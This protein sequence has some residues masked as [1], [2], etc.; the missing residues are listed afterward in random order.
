MADDEVLAEGGWAAV[1]SRAV[2]KR[3]RADNALAHYFGSVEALR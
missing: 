1:T 3:A 2:A